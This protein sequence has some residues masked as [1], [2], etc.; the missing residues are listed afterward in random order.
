MFILIAVSALV[1]SLQNSALE[2]SIRASLT[3]LA[4][5]TS[6]S[7]VRLYDT[8]K[9]SKFSP[10]TNSTVLLSVLDLKLPNDV[11]KRTYS[12]ELISANSIWSQVTSVSADQTNLTATNGSVIETPSYS[13]I[14][15]KTLQPPLVTIEYVIPNIPVVLQG[16]SENGFFDELRYYRVNFNGN[17]TDRIALGNNTLLIDL[18]VVS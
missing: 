10:T 13:R 15:A 7:I 14:I 6:D 8:S 12:I 9:D 5:Q 18:Q 4:I 2:N 3:Q 1:F 11:G 17:V 16:S